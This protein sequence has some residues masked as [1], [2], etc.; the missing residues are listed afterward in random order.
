MDWAKIIAVGTGGFI[1]AIFRYLITI[2]T[3]RL[4]PDSNFPYG[5]AIVN[6]LGCF[7]IGFLASVFEMKEWVNP[8]AR[9]LVFVGILGGFTTFS[10]FA[11]DGF[12]LF[13][14]GKTAIAILNIS[15]QIV[16]GLLLVWLGYS[17]V[18]LFQ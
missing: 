10:T 6:L 16:F 5:T 14:E 18:K 15:V 9:L 8:A 12:L 3:E 1:G 2:G 17:A 11:N 13:E 4:L 7:A